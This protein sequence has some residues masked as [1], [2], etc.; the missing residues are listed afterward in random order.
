MLCKT[1][2][3][4]SQYNLITE[5]F[6]A[7]LCTLSMQI[8]LHAP[9]D[10][11][12]QDLLPYCCCKGLTH[13]IHVANWKTYIICLLW[14]INSV[15]KL[16]ITQ[17]NCYIQL[18]SI[19]KW[20]CIGLYKKQ[21]VFCWSTMNTDFI[22]LLGLALVL[23]AVLVHCDPPRSM[24]DSKSRFQWSMVMLRPIIICCPGSSEVWIN[25]TK[26][27]LCYFISHIGLVFFRKVTRHLVSGMSSQI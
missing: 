20:E 24:C 5:L 14:A 7:H 27:F 21:D 6:R 4:K 17:Y 10:G 16:L 18:N 2:L 1:F 13:K 3:C 11:T 8:C 19:F 15:W 9:P 23:T 26:Q 22:S 12:G 25:S